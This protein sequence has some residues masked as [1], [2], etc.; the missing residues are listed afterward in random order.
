M[1]GKHGKW[2]GGVIHPT[3]KNFSNITQNSNL[4][5]VWNMEDHYVLRNAERW[6][7][8]TF[9]YPNSLG[10]RID[11]SSNIITTTTAADNADNFSVSYV[12]MS[13]ATMELA[14]GRIYLRIKVT[15]NTTYYNDFCIGA[16]QLHSDGYG[17]C[18]QSWAFSVSGDKAAWEI[19]SIPNIG[20][21][22]ANN[23]LEDLADVFNVA[24]QSWGTW[25]NSTPGWTTA[26]GTGSQ[27]TGA[28][29]GLS[30]TFSKAGQAPS[31][32]DPI[33]PGTTSIPQTAGKNYIFTETSNSGANVY[34]WIRSPEFTWSD[35]NDTT[36]AI[37]YHACTSTTSGM[38]DSA[39]DSL[40]KW[41]WTDKS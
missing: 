3:E 5:G 36:M 39:N 16:I 11:V 14:T 1:A 34:Y 25:V 23:G 9:Y 22:N 10:E 20:T 17:A 8:A 15:A 26:A 35:V 31:A 4:S 28:D 33:E 30:H 6:T 19:P 32:P 27:R 37:A 13:N 41:I 18:E 7:G 12:D 21:G 40:I 24:G 38:D 29:N 2:M